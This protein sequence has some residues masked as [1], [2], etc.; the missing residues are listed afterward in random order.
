MESQC[1]S[2]WY[3][4]SRKRDSKPGFSDLEADALTARPTRRSGQGQFSLRQCR[5]D[6][7][8]QGRCS[9]D[10]Q[11]DHH[12]ALLGTFRIVNIVFNTRTAEYTFLCK[13][14]KFVGSVVK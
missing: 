10:Q 5:H 1:F 6:S 2:H 13:E 11:I 14:K 8:E 12:A 3:D 4:S 9:I 7:A